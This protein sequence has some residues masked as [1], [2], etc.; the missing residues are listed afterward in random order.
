M[1]RTIDKVT[2]RTKGHQKNRTRD[3]RPERLYHTNIDLM[4]PTESS[5][6]TGGQARGDQAVA[7][8]SER[9]ADE[10]FDGEHRHLGGLEERDAGVDAFRIS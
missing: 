8:K 10:L 1:V 4:L 7:N 2:D 3:P 6:Q 5:Q 9:S